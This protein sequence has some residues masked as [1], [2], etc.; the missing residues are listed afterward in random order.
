MPIELLIAVITALLVALT[1][2]LVLLAEKLQV[3]Q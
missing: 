1:R 3:R 2:G